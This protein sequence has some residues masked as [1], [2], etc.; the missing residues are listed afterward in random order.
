MFGGFL[1]N[2]IGVSFC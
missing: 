1:R 2:E